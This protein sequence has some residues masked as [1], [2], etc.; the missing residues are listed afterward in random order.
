[1]VVALFLTCF[2]LTVFVEAC[3]LILGG[4]LISHTQGMHT[5][6]AVRIVTYTLDPYDTL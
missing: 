6:A 4:V 5:V 1:L 2:D 3:V